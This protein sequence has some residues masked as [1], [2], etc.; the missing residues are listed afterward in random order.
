MMRRHRKKAIL[1]AQ[2]STAQVREVKSIS[3]RGP[4]GGVIG[5]LNHNPEG[6]ICVI[7]SVGGIGDML[8]LTP[9]LRELKRRFPNSHL[10]VAIDRH[11]TYDDTYYKLYHNSPFIDTIIDARYVNRKKYH[12]FSDVSSV[13]IPYERSDLPPRNRIDMF[14][15]HLGVHKMENWLP[16]YVVEI[17]E[18]AA[19]KKIVSQ[20]K[21]K[22]RKKVVA[23]H[24]ASMEGKR[25]WPASNTIDFVKL[26]SKDKSILT[27]VFDFNNV[28]KKWDELPGVHKINADVRQMA[29]LIEQ[30]DIFIGPDSGPMHLAG[31][32]GTNSYVLF[33]SIPP[34][35]RINHY[36][37]H[38]A[39]TAD[40][41]CLGCWYKPCPYD[42]RC[43]KDI[44]PEEVRV[45]TIGRKNEI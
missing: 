2:R 31:A 14:A 43:M 39:I 22:T 12:Q 15:N 8:M 5:H 38:T 7:R 13:C 21:T 27:L 42:V 36:P 28:Y 20:L 40:V 30:A 10:T 3:R 23:V 41:P 45:Y 25:S 6:S 9:A 26:L 44:T 16:F 24:T 34:E 32:V 1:Q 29:A 37:T 35:A 19:A 18:R 17:Q 4:S 11:R 33:G